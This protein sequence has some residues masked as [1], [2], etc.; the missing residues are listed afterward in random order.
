MDGITLAELRRQLVIRW[1]KLGDLEARE[2][3][4]TREASEA[5]TEMIDIAQSLELLGRQ[6]SL[7]D[8]ERRELLMIE[9]ALTKMASSTF[10][11]CEDCQEEIPERRLRVVPEARFCATCQAME[12]RKGIRL[13]R[14]M[15]S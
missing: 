4:A 8:Q 1:R 7:A 3:E 9:R 6:S 10:G 15:A 11:V 12:E 13:P 5:Q 14:A 2:I